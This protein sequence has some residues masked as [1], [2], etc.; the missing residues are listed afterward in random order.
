MIPLSIL[1]AALFLLLWREMCR[2]AALERELEQWRDGYEAR[3][4]K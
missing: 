1:S 3:M 2:S 4:R